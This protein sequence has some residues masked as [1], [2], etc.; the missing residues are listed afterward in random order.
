MMKNNKVKTI[1]ALKVRLKKIVPEAV[2]KVMDSYGE[3]FESGIPQDA[4]GFAAHHAACKSAVV[5]A[6]TLLK[7]AKW[8]E[9]EGQ[10][11]VCEKDDDIFKMI[12]EVK[13]EINGLGE[14]ED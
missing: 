2:M 8:T 9:D 7:L 5:H 6:E 13:Q 11:S 10:S 1:K 3:F 4:K 12:E 14:D